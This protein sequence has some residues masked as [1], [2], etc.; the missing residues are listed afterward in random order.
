MA[1]L[2]HQLQHSPPAPVPPKAKP[3]EVSEPST[4]FDRQ[5]LALLSRGGFRGSGRPNSLAL[6]HRP[7]V[8]PEQRGNI[9]LGLADWTQ[10]GR[11]RSAPAKGLRSGLPDAS[12]PF[13]H[14]AN[15]R[16]A[17]GLSIFLLVSVG[18][19]FARWWGS[20][21][22]A[23]PPTPP[24]LAVLEVARP[25]TVAADISTPTPSKILRWDRPRSVCS[26]KPV[27]AG[28]SQVAFNPNRIARRL[29]QG[30]PSKIRNW[31][32]LLINLVWLG[33]RF[34]IQNETRSS[35]SFSRCC[36]GKHRKTRL[37]L[38]GW[39]DLYPRRGLLN[40]NCQ[41][42][43][44]DWRFWLSWNVLL[45]CP[46]KSVRW[47]RRPSAERCDPT[48]RPSNEPK[49]EWLIH[50]QRLVEAMN[51]ERDRSQAAARWMALT[52]GGVQSS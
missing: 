20:E 40:P 15:L 36:F 10:A 17:V 48:A 16:L 52:H 31:F 49:T 27:L 12:L 5:L 23:V 2:C 32:A 4:V 51:N 21:S 11:G 39:C 3:S 8:T 14:K 28:R 35:G 25:P 24:Q 1:V 46:P 42:L 29:C 37:N 9:K 44:L 26:S 38:A 13:D 33:L 41:M 43:G 6:A 34:R 7:T 19:L 30:N 50:S 18:I 22:A 45:G 47:F